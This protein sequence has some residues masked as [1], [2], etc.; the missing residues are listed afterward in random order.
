MIPGNQMAEFKDAIVS[1]CAIAVAPLE[2]YILLSGSF[3]IYSYQ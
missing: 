1:R 2:F 3:G